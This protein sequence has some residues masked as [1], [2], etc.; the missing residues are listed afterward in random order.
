LSAWPDVADQLFDNMLTL[1]DQ[2]GA[3][4]DNRSPDQGYPALIVFCVYVCGSLANHLHQQPQICSKAAPRAMDV[5]KKSI[6]GLADLQGA[7]P[8]VQRWY[9]ALC[10][11]AESTL[12]SNTDSRMAF[13]PF[14]TSS[15]MYGSNTEASGSA[16][17]ADVHFNDPFPSDFLFEAF[18]SYLWSDVSALNQNSLASDT[19]GLSAWNY[20]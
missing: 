4:F 19:S 1:H 14:T 5:L 7:W 15:P 10:H 2:I 8:L 6:K 16:A 20:G 13:Q 18:E 3:F 12:A 11:A 9:N 17:V